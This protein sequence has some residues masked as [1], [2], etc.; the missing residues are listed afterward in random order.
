[1][2]DIPKPIVDLTERVA[3]VLLHEFHNLVCPADIYLA[4][5]KHPKG[6]HAYQVAQL[7][8]QEIGDQL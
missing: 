4:D 5:T 2:S 6:I 1:M 7:L 8:I 3:R